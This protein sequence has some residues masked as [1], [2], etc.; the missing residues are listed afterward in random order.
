VK[1]YL[2][3]KRA[4][5]QGVTAGGQTVSVGLERRPTGPKQP[6]SQEITWD[7]KRGLFVLRVPSWTGELRHIWETLALDPKPPA[8]ADRGVAEREL[9]AALDE[10][11]RILL[12]GADVA[13][14]KIRYVDPAREA[15]KP[16]GSK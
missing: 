10:S 1:G 2:P 4:T 13:E 6:W 11:E 9:D 7:E 8:P 14:V 3:E 5:F 12:K 15:I 16:K